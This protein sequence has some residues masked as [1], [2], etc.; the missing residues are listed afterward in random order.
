MIA[1]GVAKPSAHGQE[2]TNTAIPI[3]SANSN[4]Y[5]KISHTMVAIT[6]MV[7]TTGTKIPLILSANFAM[8]A[9]EA[10]ASSTNWII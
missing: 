4:G 3:E 5:P 1:T 8:G 6:A 7:M 2:I 9:F 10:F